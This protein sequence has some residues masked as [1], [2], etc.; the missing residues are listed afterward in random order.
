MGRRTTARER[1]RPRPRPPRVPSHD[2]LP[3][4]PRAVPVRPVRPAPDRDDGRATGRAIET[5]ADLPR[6]DADPP[7][8]LIPASH[9]SE[10]TLT[11]VGRRV[12]AARLDPKGSMPPASMA[13]ALGAG[14]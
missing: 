5:A 4:S 8:T 14:R 6:P 2:G 13:L 1:R 11:R 9:G 7:P 12:H 10:R 3:R